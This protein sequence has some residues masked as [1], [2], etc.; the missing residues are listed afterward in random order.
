MKPYDPQM[1]CYPYTKKTDGHYLVVKKNDGQ[2]FDKNYP[3]VDDSKEYKF[4]RFW[5]KVITITM[6]MPLMRI[7]TLLKKVVERT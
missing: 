7:R 6:A 2:I 1:T 3:Y 4:K 5:L